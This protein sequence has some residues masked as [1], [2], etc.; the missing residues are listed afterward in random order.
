MTGRIPPSTHARPWLFAAWGDT[1]GGAPDAFGWASLTGAS[2][3]DETARAAARAHL[4]RSLVILR[5]PLLEAPGL[6]AL[7]AGN[8]PPYADWFVALARFG[9]ARSWAATLER[10]DRDMALQDGPAVHPLELAARRMRDGY[11]AIAARAASTQRS[12]DS[13]RNAR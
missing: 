1:K 7:F 8:P 2:G 3:F 4:A 6:I 13:G 11:G 12:F 10:V 5:D 9:Q